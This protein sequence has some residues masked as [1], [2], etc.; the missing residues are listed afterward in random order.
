MKSSKLKQLFIGTA[1]LTLSFGLYFTNP[2]YC[3]TFR[4]KNVSHEQQNEEPSYNKYADSLKGFKDERN[5]RVFDDIEIYNLYKNHVPAEYAK[6][7]AGI[8]DTRGKQMFNSSWITLL[9]DWKANEEDIK[10]LASIKDKNDNPRFKKQDLVDLARGRVPAKYVDNLLSNEKKDRGKRLSGFNIRRFY[11]F[12]F[13]KGD[14]TEEGLCKFNETSKPNAIMVYTTLDYGTAFETEE[15]LK[16]LENIKSHYDAYIVLVSTEQEI[17]QAIDN[18]PNA[19]LLVLSGHGT[20][21]TLSLGIETPQNFLEYEQYLIDT[22]DDELSK[23]L[24]KLSPNA[25][26]FLNS[27]SNAQGGEKA[28]NLANFVIKNSGGRKVI[29]SKETFEGK[30]VRIKSLYPFD[31]QIIKTRYNT[32]LLPGNEKETDIT[33]TNK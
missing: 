27:C 32:S 14:I 23:H 18:I 28:D 11:Q 33:Y 29:A 3:E 8:K 30:D 6:T 4:K 7:L 12:G 25:V 2:A 21:K 22:S 31:I 19:E 24:S 26:I 16:L 9:N 15:D 20:P 10:A 1:A 17:Y 13:T 5:K